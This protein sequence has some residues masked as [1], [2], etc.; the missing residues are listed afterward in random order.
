MI[1]N[2]S[3]QPTESLWLIGFLLDSDT[4]SPDFYTL[5]FPGET[6]EPLQNKSYLIFFSDPQL[7]SHALTFAENDYNPAIHLLPIEIDLV[8]DAAQMLYLLNHAEID[9]EATIINCLNIMFDLVRATTLPM[10][11]EYK[12]LLYALADHLTFERELTPFF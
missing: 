4:A 9:N 5:M 2:T 7:A 6:D 10:P 11:P 12:Q 8:C 1:Q 3:T